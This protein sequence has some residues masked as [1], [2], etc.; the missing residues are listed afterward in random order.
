MTG[1]LFDVLVVVD[2]AGPSGNA[3]FLLGRVQAALERAGASDEAI[4]DYVTE[5]TSGD[6]DNLLAVTRRYV[7]LEV[8]G[9]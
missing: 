9:G 6:Y 4:R 2:L 1:T 5:A 8:V 7:N 3:Y